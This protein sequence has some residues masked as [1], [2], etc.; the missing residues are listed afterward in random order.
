MSIYKILLFF[1][2]VLNYSAVYHVTPPYMSLMYMSKI[3]FDLFI[4]L[5]CIN[6]C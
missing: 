3:K 4:H 1:K 2:I 6:L 5:S